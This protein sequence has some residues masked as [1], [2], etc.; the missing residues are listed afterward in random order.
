MKLLVVKDYEEMSSV[1]SEIFKDIITEKAD[2]VLGLATG[3]TP[4]GLYKK[5]I[6]MNKNKEI[7][8]S[9]IKT[10]N[11]DEYVGLGEEDPQSYRYF[12]NKNLFNHINIDKANTF[13]PNGLAEDLEK[14]TKS[15]D[16]KIEELGGIDIQILGIGSNGHIAFNEPD[17]FLISE[18]HVT[19]L[20]KSTIEANSRFFKS[21]NEVPTRAITMGIGQ[22][23][24]AKKVL[25]LVK[26][27]DKTEVIKELLDGNITTN[28]PATMLKLHKD[29]T[30]VI[31]ETMKNKIKKS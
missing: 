24:K 4:I 7:D 19:N 10:V 16:E 28:N 1:V 3:S 8:F 26:G 23:M 6:E 30:I 18:T 21:I 2:A 13:V 17:D 9:N 31:D 22:I 12:M 29:A 20:A 5:L 27:E 25:L 15:Y 11:L 14:E